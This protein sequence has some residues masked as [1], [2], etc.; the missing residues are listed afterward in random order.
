MITLADMVAGQSFLYLSEAVV[1]ESIATVDGDELQIRLQ[2]GRLMIPLHRST[3]FELV[4]TVQ[5]LSLVAAPQAGIRPFSV[6]GR[7]YKL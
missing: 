1:V 2:D 5:Q 3:P 6:D 7:T 4:G